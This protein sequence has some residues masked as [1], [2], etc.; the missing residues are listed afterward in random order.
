MEWFHP[1]TV[2][3]LTFIEKS[4]DP[5]RYPIITTSPVDLMNVLHIYRMRVAVE[6]TTIALLQR[7]RY[8]HAGRSSTTSPSL[9]QPGE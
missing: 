1:V 6:G 8:L 7:N 2:V 3:S 9:I 4:Q 5:K